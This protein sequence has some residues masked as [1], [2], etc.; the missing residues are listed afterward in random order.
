MIELAASG[1][2]PKP[3]DARRRYFAGKNTTPWQ[4]RQTHAL[5]PAEWREEILDLWTDCGA[6]T[7]TG[8]AP[9]AMGGTAFFDRIEL[10]QEKS[11]PA[12]RVGHPGDNTR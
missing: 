5:A 11:E 2:W 3:E 8:I 4:A 6:F 9:T 10:I 7:L 12:P 1:Q